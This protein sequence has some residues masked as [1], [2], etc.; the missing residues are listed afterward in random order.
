MLS[1]INTKRT[2]PAMTNEFSEETI[3]RAFITLCNFQ[4]SI[5][6]SE[7]LLTICKD[8]PD[9]LKKMDTIQE[10]ILK[11]KRDG[12]SYTKEQFLRLFQIVSR[13]NIIK[14]SL[15]T[16]DTSCI[17]Q[18]QKLLTK[19]EEEDNDNV[20]KAL[21]QKMEK[22]VETYDVTMKEDTRDMRNLK[23]YLQSSIEKMRKELLEFIKLKG[24]ISSVD[25]KNITNFV[26]DITKWKFDENQRNA[27]IKI[28]DDGLYNYVNFM[29][30]YIELFVIVF[31]SMILHQ[32][33]Q[34]IEPPKYWGL[35]RDHANDVREMV[36]DFYRPIEKFYGDNKIQNVLNEIMTKSRGIY[37][38]SQNTPALTSIKINDN[39]VHTSFDKRITVLLYEYYFLSVL[40]DYI[41]LTKDPSMVTRVLVV[42]EKEKSD[43]FS[44]DFLVEQQLRFT[45]DEQE[46][47][48]GN[49]MELNKEVAKLLTAFLNIMIKSKKTIN[50]SYEDIEDKVFRLKE[51]EKYDF[52]DK[53]KDMTDEERAVDTILKH[54]K[55]GPLY[56]LGMSKGIKEYDPDHFEY[57]KKIAENVTKIQNNMRRKGALGDDMDL[58]DAIDE[59][60]LEREIDMDLAGDF[61]PT[62]D[63]DDGDP[64]GEELADRDDYD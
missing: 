64:W 29:K 52:T 23:D 48:E 46:F 15:S 22:I 20:P 5:P 26:K 41:Y 58:E 61:N 55:L 50:V 54:N 17:S 30:S 62:D 45:E 1:E 4:S 11:L 35:A 40:T 25:L 38:L 21:I 32:K 31:P 34:S 10:K 53:L 24:K 56:S 37:L 42:P 14:I 63:F 16:K 51:A 47:I 27:D 12:R 57:D 9:Y 59:M 44:A 2:F 60:N 33:I 13:N 7:E 18:L 36:S 39:E 6:L 49:V 19:F 8:K 43:I 28:S 3:Y